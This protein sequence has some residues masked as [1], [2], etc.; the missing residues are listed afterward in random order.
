MYIEQRQN[1]FKM[2]N[3]STVNLIYSQKK[4]VPKKKNKGLLQ[5]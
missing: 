4:K 3:L 5:Q 2:S 1:A